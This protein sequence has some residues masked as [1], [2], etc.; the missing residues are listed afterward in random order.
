MKPWLHR[1]SFLALAAASLAPVVPAPLALGAGVA[2][3]LLFG[4]PWADASKQWSTRLLQLSV[5]GLGAAMNLGQ[6]AAAGARG[7]AGTLVGI[8]AALAVS[9]ALGRLLRTEPT[10]GVLVGVGTAICG[11]S[12]I[13][14]V[15]PVVRARPEQTS[16]ALAV[17]FVLNAVAL[18]LFPRLGHALDL[19]QEQFGVWAALAI[20]DTSSVVGAGLEYG[21]RALELATTV[22]LARALWIVPL[23]LVAA[24]LWA[25]KDG[26]AS[27]KPKKPWFI[28]GFVLAAAL[29]TFVPP[30]QAPGALVAVAARRLLVLTLFLIGAGLTRKALAQVGGRALLHGVLLWVLVAAG[31]L[32]AVLAGAQL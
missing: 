2:F 13:A 4:N 8:T 20:H 10:T 23:A 14:A 19:S 7:F 9:H 3:G 15:A 29:V 11:G 6:V 16:V 1:G 25:P 24:R 22:K 28:L 5:V 30:L 17:V 21:P 18:L 12:A 26:A 27:A 32:A 31:S